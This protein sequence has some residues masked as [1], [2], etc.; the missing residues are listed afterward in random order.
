MVYPSAFRE[1]DALRREMDGL[2]LRVQEMDARE[3]V[4]KEELSKLNTEV[5]I[6]H[7]CTMTHTYM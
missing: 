7:D 4:I 2:K 6:I 5:S 3:G 1:R